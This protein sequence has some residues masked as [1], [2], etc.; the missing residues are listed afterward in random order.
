[1]VVVDAT[2]GCSTVAK[3]YFQALGA[4]KQGQGY[5]PDARTVPTDPVSGL[6]TVQAHCG[7]DNGG[8]LLET[9]LH[10][11]QGRAHAMATLAQRAH[12]E[13]GDTLTA[14]HADNATVLNASQHP[15][16]AVDHDWYAQVVIDRPI[17][18]ELRGYRGWHHWHGIDAK[19]QNGANTSVPVAHCVQGL[20]VLLALSAAAVALF[21]NSPLE[22]GRRTGFKEHRL[23]LW[24]RMFGPSRFPGDLKLATYP[25]RPFRDLAD[26]FH[27]M[28]GPG[29]VSRGLP[30]QGCGDYKATD[31]VFLRGD[32]CLL[33]FLQA[34][35]WPVLS[36]STGK[37]SLLAPKAEH[38]V[39]SQIGQF[40]DARIRYRLAT[41]PDVSQL[42][43]AWSRDGGLEE[44]FQQC[45]ASM[46]LE[47]RAP[48]AGFADGA[49]MRDAGLPEARSILMAP[50]ALQTG[51]LSNLAQA[52]ALVRDRGWAELGAL[53]YD[54]MR[55]GLHDPNVLALCRDVL[56]VAAGGLAPGE[57]QWLA[58]AQYALA[59][60]RSGAD[61]LLTTWNSV[62]GGVAERLAAVVR[63]HRAL[64]PD[65]YF[66]P[67]ALP[68]SNAG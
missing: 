17:Y 65:D 50:T 21:A 28:F 3:H 8:N 6:D 42:L 32:P 46:Y 55:F 48:G 41:L 45:G 54:A 57:R 67:H 18:R 58:Y 34:R 9:S 60:G 13:L 19:A 44:L 11:V 24:P 15:A 38:F 52:Q 31:V 49:L 27:W 12:G 56:A 1:M 33:H 26:F 35:S 25:Q 5:C 16:C 68:D 29:T 20:N 30:V 2:T 53:R 37:T 36:P 61:R 10:P 62:P 59:S 43:R 47:A 64:H 22:Q 14:L 66:P 4:V 23:T 51:L 39:Y 40:L 7:L 63:Q